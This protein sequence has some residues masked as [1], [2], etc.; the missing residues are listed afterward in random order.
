MRKESGVTAEQV[1]VLFHPA[2]RSGL[3]FAL[4]ITGLAALAASDNVH[5]ALNDLLAASRTI[6]AGHPVLG[7]LL[8]VLLAALSAMLAFA[9]VAVLLPLAV[10]TWG[11]PMSILLLWI[12]W[13]LGGACTYLAGRCLGPRIVGWLKAGPLLRRLEHHV[14]PATPF[15]LVLLFQLALPSEI[16]G[17]VLGLVRYSARKY[18]LA[19]GMAELVYTLAAVHLGASFVERRAGM[20]FITGGA[21][22]LLSLAAV[23]L[24]RK[25]I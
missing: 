22:A 23:Y 3:I 15:G 18:L 21:V 24:L 10:F 4:L 5:A 20:V 6:I 2:W 17:Y 19:L 16:P 7:P 8:F 12:G 9:S 11:E 1:P 14:G 13:S 25:R